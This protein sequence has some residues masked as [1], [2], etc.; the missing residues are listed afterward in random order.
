MADL[1]FL[2]FHAA[3]GNV[4]VRRDDLACVSGKLILSAEVFK[5]GIGSGACFSG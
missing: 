3:A 4:L 1:S 5:R 2:C